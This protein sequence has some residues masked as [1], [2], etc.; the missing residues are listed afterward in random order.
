VHER[1]V[2][3]R[4]VQINVSNVRPGIY[5]L[6]IDAGGKSFLRKVLVNP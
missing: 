3:S 2:K 1:A 6:K 4:D 5:V